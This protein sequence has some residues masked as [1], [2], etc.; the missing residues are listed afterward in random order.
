MTLAKP[1][2][3]LTILEV[4]NAVEPIGRI[5]TCPLGLSSHG[6]NLCPLHRR[7]DAALAASRTPSAGRPWPRS[8]PSRQKKSRS[9]P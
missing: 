2:G 8:S 4:V 5:K 3:E 6:V 9:A 1:P 7:L